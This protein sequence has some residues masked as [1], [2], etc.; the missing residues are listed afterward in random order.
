MK[1]Q[2]AGNTGKLNKLQFSYKD[3]Q[4]AY[5]FYPAMYGY[6]RFEVV[7]NT[8]SNG[9]DRKYFHAAGKLDSKTMMTK[10]GQIDQI[11]KDSLYQGFKGEVEKK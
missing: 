3:E 4:Y 2:M 6:P 11:I 5:N 10:E 9:F 7:D 8:F 1:D